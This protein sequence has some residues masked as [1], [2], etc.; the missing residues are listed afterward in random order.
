[1]L[2]PGAGGPG[3]LLRGISQ[4]SGSALASQFTGIALRSAELGDPA[5]LR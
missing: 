1:M 2:C 4:A 3:V 5:V